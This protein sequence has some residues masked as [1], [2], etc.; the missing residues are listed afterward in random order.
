MGMGFIRR[1]VYIQGGC[2]LLQN[3]RILNS[4]IDV[5]GLNIFT[6]G[7]EENVWEWGFI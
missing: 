6:F 2:I 7:R 5:G 3:G 4:T 1:N